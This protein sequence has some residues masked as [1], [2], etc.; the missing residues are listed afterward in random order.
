MVSKIIT[1]LFAINIIS[2]ANGF[3]N[4]KLRVLEPMLKCYEGKAP[5]F[6]GL[7]ALAAHLNLDSDAD[8]LKLSCVHAQVSSQT[9]LMQ[10][11]LNQDI[12]KWD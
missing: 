4:S 5:E 7:G 1:V 10:D 8:D 3:I 6:A 2:A 12:F 11:K 9:K